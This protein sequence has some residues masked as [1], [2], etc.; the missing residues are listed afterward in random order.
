MFEKKSGPG[1]SS[2]VYTR[3][4]NKRYST[5]LFTFGN[6]KLNVRSQYGLR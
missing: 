4:G 3:K 5:A 1:Y 6:G 2:K